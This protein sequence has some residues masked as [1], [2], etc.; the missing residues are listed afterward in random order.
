MEGDWLAL[1]VADD[2]KGFDCTQDGEAG[3]PAAS[4]GRGGNGIPSMRRRAGEMGGRFEITSTGGKGTTTRLR[5]FV[6]KQ[7]ANK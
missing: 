5:V 2:G 7:P 1:E 6:P 4:G 3:P